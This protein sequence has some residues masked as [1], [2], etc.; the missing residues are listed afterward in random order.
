MQGQET[1]QSPQ[2]A[3][4][5]VLDDD[6]LLGEIIIRVT[7]PTSL[8]RVALV[9]KRWLSLASAPAFLRR[10]RKLHP[11]SLLGVYVFS[12]HNNGPRFVPMSQPPELQA[13]LHS[14]SFN[15]DAL[16]GH[17]KAPECWNGLLLLTSLDHDD[18]QRTRTVRW[19][20]YP[21][22]N[23]TILP[24]VPT[25]FN[26][27]DGFICYYWDHDILPNGGDNALSFFCLALG[28]KDQQTIVHLYVLQDDIWAIHSKV[29][30]E[31]P[32][33]E[34]ITSSL[35]A[36][37]KIYNLVTVGKT[38]KLFVLDLVSS[39]FS[40][41][42]LPEDGWTVGLSLTQRTGV[43]LTHV[44]DCQL[45]I[46]LIVMDT[47]GV[48]SWFLVDTIFLREIC[49]NH[50][51]PTRIFEDVGDSDL[52]IHAV[53]DNSEF[54]LMELDGVLLYLLDIKRKA[55]RKVYKLTP[56]D[57]YFFSV[58]PVLM[59]WPPKFPVIKLG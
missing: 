36:D 41:V 11:P 33:I 21:T 22:R 25:F 2:A 40:L 32:M 34:L 44:K 52:T 18:E 30:I 48:H 14:G 54:V 5:A 20:L 37:M 8:V 12:M 10:F 56:T 6:D 1:P 4:S 15:L 42:N 27:D 46:W 31:I 58:T 7:F 23:T 55:A 39:S 45:R 17:V 38:A 26:L 43:H 13:V 28:Y 53:W 19:P 57:K 59:V 29:V 3:I 35:I 51:I 24:P 50:M 47:N 49:A 9:C 16:I